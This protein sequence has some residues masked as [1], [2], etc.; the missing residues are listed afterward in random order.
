MP[1]PHVVCDGPIIP[2]LPVQ[3]ADAFLLLFA[4]GVATE[5]D[6]VCPGSSKTGLDPLLNHGA[7]KLREHAQHLEQRFAGWAVR[8]NTFQAADS[9]PDVCS[10]EKGRAFRPAP[11]FALTRR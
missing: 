9:T 4:N 2:A 10:R 6:A 1:A 8:R 7:L 11:K 5:L 3:F